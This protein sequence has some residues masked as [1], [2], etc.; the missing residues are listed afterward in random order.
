MT[1]QQ[2]L[3][4]IEQLPDNTPILVP[5]YDHGYRE[6]HAEVTTALRQGGIWT[7]DWGEESTPEAEYGKREVV[8]VI[9]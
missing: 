1:K 2:L 4:L 3:R 7:E 5:A 6:P 9:T 8:V